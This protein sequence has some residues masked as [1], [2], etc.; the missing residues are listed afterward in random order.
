MKQLIVM[1]SFVALMGAG[2]VRGEAKVEAVKSGVTA[3]VTLA[4]DGDRLYM[5]ARLSGIASKQTVSCHVEWK[6]PDVSYTHKDGHK[7][8]LFGEGGR[9]PATKEWTAGDEKGSCYCSDTK[10]KGCW[11]TR[12]NWLTQYDMETGKGSKTVRAVGTWTVSIVDAD[13]KTLGSATYE[14]K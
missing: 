13:G 14:V 4:E 9:L 2:G 10:E 8:R 12:A 11:R 3:V 5:K 1:T 6:A 7:T